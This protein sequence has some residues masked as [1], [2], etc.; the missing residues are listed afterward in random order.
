MAVLEDGKPTILAGATLKGVR[1]A[2]LETQ[3][4]SGIEDTPRAA[5]E[6]AVGRLAAAG[7]TVER[8]DVPA[9]EDATR[10]GPTVFPAEAYATWAHRIEA[11]GDL[12]YA[13]V[14]QRFL[15]GKTI[16]AADFINA[17]RELDCLRLVYREAV[18][19]FD[20][21]IL[22]SCPIMPPKAAALLADDPRH[23]AFLPDLPLGSD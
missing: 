2:I 1:L 10:L 7:A 12:M 16:S 18:A 13:P 19:G 6:D 4:F 20:A 14:R 11:D 5:F 22:P 17:W 9:V 21:V 3:A 15:Q 23:P 8:I